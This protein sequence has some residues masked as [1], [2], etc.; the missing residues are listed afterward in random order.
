MISRPYLGDIQP[1]ILVIF[2]YFLV[3]SSYFLVIS[4]YFLVIQLLNLGDI[5][6]LLLIFSYSSCWYS[7]LT[8]HV[9]VLQSNTQAGLSTEFDNSLKII[10]FLGSHPDQVVHDLNL[11]LQSGVLYQFDHFFR[12]FLF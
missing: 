10:D 11:H 4:S 2:S 3:I 9:D 7:T 5:H 8:P 6:L 1:L 12:V